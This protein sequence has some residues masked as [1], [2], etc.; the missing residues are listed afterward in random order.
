MKNWFTSPNGALT[1]SV[2]ALLVFLG[3]AFVDFYYVYAEFGLG[4]GM[5]ALANLIHLALFGGWIWSLLAAVQG[6][7][8]GWVAAFGI[9]LFFLLAIA[10]GTLVSYCPSPCSTAWPVGEIFIW[11][12]LIFGLFA[13]AA[14]GIQ[15]WNNHSSRMHHAAGA[16]S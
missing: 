8:P 15:L 9:S 2:L 12:S 10:V 6:S 11:L 16:E 5:V 3:R 7:R 1:I 13:S 4:V 14:T